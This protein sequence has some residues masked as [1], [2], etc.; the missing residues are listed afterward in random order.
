[1]DA[2]HTFQKRT[3]NIFAFAVLIHHFTR[4]ISPS[5]FSRNKQFSNPSQGSGG[6]KRE[7]KKNPPKFNKISIRD[8]YRRRE[9]HKKQSPER[10]R[11]R[12]YTIRV[13]RRNG[14][15]KRAIFRD[16]SRNP[17]RGNIS[18][19]ETELA[20]Y[21][22]IEIN[23]DRFRGNLWWISPQV[24]A[25]SQKLTA[26]SLFGFLL[27]SFSSRHRWKRNGVGWKK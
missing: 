3:R 5:L 18:V 21:R 4:R 23:A 17:R 8:C 22:G 13:T 14:R 20:N 9:K 1:M 27:V 25:L 16:Q 19:E 2:V 11:G 15:A 24:A 26:T 12:G 10:R 6:K 7:R